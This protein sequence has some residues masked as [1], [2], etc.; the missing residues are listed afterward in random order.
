MGK[1]TFKPEKIDF[2]SCLP[3]VLAIT[4]ICVASSCMLET[5]HDLVQ[6]LSSSCLTILVS[7]LWYALLT[8]A[9]FARF[10]TKSLCQ[11]YTTPWSRS[12]KNQE[13]R[14]LVID[15]RRELDSGEDL[16]L[17]TSQ[18]SLKTILCHT[19]DFRHTP[20]EVRLFVSREELWYILYPMSMGVFVLFYSLPVYDASCVISLFM[21]L[22]AKSTYDEV[23]R[24]FFWKRT[25][26][27]KFFFVTMTLCG[28]ICAV[29]LSTL[30][31]SL[32]RH[33]H[34]YVSHSNAST[35]MDNNN[36]MLGTLLHEKT[37]LR[38]NEDTPE[39]V[40]GYTDAPTE[41]DETV[42]PTQKTYNTTHLEALNTSANGSLSNN[43]LEATSFSEFGEAESVVG[44]VLDSMMDAV[45]ESTSSVQ[46]ISMQYS[47][48]FWS[49]CFYTPFF[50]SRVPESTRLPVLLEILQPSVSCLA[51]LG[52][53]L[54][55]L[56]DP[57]ARSSIQALFESRA[58]VFYI[59]FIAG[60]IWVGVYFMIKALRNK[61]S[62]YACSLLT[63]SIFFKLLYTARADAHSNHTVKSVMAFAGCICALY[64]VLT[65]TFIRMENK[66]IQ[67]GW[68]T[69]AEEEMLDLECLSDSDGSVREHI[70][71]PRYC[72]EDVLER[73]SQDIQAT[74][75]VLSTQTKMNSLPHANRKDKLTSV[76]EQDTMPPV[77]HQ[78]ENES[79][80]ELDPLSSHQDTSSTESV[81]P[82]LKTKTRTKVRDTPL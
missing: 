24:G 27:R 31:V 12:E 14:G 67:L 65:V 36:N 45:M 57:D 34:V 52:L 73:V 56:I 61:T 77:E 42:S 19:I 40:Y 22:L 7:N 53:F 15:D 3:L 23:R 29:A 35:P 60:P 47:I 30:T 9:Q 54:C 66:S 17:I 37:I 78:H 81:P 82:V 58:F 21:G 68:D 32:N 6:N 48:M 39:E 13:K 64:S 80:G 74:E 59:L 69:E 10:W 26:G 76:P 28:A 63:I 75:I 50:L 46:S 25:T 8:S 71:S 44:D 2:S 43:S 5:H 55:T 72:I 51:S 79:L 70:V 18:Y 4:A 38:Q 16:A 62:S 11:K 41:S 20:R 49:F 1:Y 33:K